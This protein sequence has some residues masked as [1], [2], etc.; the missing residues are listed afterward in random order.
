MSHQPNSMSLLRRLC[1][2]LYQI[3]ANS[4][5][6][7]FR[8]IQDEIRIDLERLLNTR[9]AISIDNQQASITTAA[10]GMFDF[11]VIDFSHEAGK[12]ELCSRIAKVIETHEPRLSQVHVEPSGEFH[13]FDQFA[14]RIQAQVNL[15]PPEDIAFES[16]L[17]PNTQQ[18][19]LIQG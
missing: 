2:E 13:Q 19:T 6:S 1:P 3:N 4:C 11:M 12:S 17:E 8:E 10:Y 18:F 15:N 5:T 9:A 14:I 7:G 16:E